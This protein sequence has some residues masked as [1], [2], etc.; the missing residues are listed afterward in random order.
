MVVRATMTVLQRLEDD[1]KPSD[2]DDSKTCR[3]RVLLIGEIEYAIDEWRKIEEACEIV[4]GFTH[5]RSPVSVSL[6][7]V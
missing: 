2:I 7:R 1:T 4:V 6:T 5:C 3:P